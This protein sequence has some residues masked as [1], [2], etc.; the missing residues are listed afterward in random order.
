M[1][2]FK[3]EQISATMPAAQLK[4]RRTGKSMSRRSGQSGTIVIQS[5]WYRVRWRL[6]VE[7]QERRINMTAKIAPVVLDR[8]GNPRPL[9]LENQRKAREI[10]EQ[11]GAN[12]KQHFNRVVLGEVTF[13][14]QAEAYLEW[15]VNRGREPIKDA[16]TI[17]AALNKWILPAIG[18]LPLANVNNVT[19]KPL[20]DKMKKSLSARTVNTYVGYVQQVVASL[21]DGETGEPIHR[22]KWDSSVMDLPLVKSKEQRRPSLKAG[23]VNHL[24]KESE[25]DEQALYVLL[26]AI[27]LRVSESIGARI[28]ALRKRR[29][30]DR[31]SATGGP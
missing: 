3:C 6:D 24:V 7:G 4:Q 19:V 12:S 20:V 21:R 14:Q 30:D 25:G 15:A 18:D 22:R 8:A 9:S 10:V 16:S 28:Q 23:A 26:G 27:G 1:I 2:A 29:T 17:E 5:G 31:N 13:R 11:S